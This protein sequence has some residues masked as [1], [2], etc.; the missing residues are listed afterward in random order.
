MIHLLFYTILTLCADVMNTN[1]TE[2]KYFDTNA[3]ND[4][5]KC[6]KIIYFSNKCRNFFI[7]N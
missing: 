2:N 6:K 4:V 5:E 3:S 1:F 7:L